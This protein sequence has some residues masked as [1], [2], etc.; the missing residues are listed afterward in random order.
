MIFWLQQDPRSRIQYK[1]HRPLQ[2]YINTLSNAGLYT[3]HF[4]EWI[5]HKKE[6]KGIKSE[7]IDNAREEFPMFLCLKATKVI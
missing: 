6:Q 1:E 3:T 2:A 5:S 7:A 4:D